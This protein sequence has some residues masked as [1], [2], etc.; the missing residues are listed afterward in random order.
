MVL[1]SWIDSY[2]II[3]FRKK[4]SHK[5]APYKDS[6]VESWGISKIWAKGAESSK[7]YVSFVIF[8]ALC[9][10]VFQLSILCVIFLNTHKPKNT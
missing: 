8:F 2:L 9:L 10:C 6:A 3:Y 5:P 1:E 4:P 7:F